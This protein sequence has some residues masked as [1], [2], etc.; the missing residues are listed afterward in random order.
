MVST[1][2]R[3]S[4]IFVSLSVLLLGHGLQQTLIPLSAVA[5]GWST[6][7]IALLGAG[8]F[9]GFIIGCYRIPRWIRRV[10]HARVF[11]ANAGL[12]VLAVLCFKF[13]NDL[14]AWI[15]LRALTGFS[16]AG[17]YLVIESWLNSATPNERRGTV[18]SF[19]TV[20]SLLALTVGQWFATLDLTTGIVLVAIA[21]S[22]AIYPIAL[23]GTSQPDVPSNVSLSF[24]ETYNASQVAPLNAAAAGFIMAL[25]WSVGAVF[26]AESLNSPHVGTTFVSFVLL[27]GVFSLLPIGRLSD[28]LDRRWVMFGTSAIGAATATYAWYT[29]ASFTLIMGSGFVI[30]ATAMPLYSLAIAHANDN[31]QDNFLIV[32]GTLLVANGIGAVVAP[33]LYAVLTA[34]LSI[35]DPFFL[36]ISLG[37]FLTSLWTFARIVIHPVERNYFEPYQPVSRTTFG[38]VELD[39][40]ADELTV[41]VNS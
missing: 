40:R 7:L 34:Y 11:A 32:G 38:A 23:S 2:T 8:Y 18:M 10:R 27:G 36:L 20:L 35:Q 26:A 13:T 5:L 21:F 9:C 33:L 12:A 17:L 6:S 22:V 4:S 31:A 1:L 14:W 39:P 24:S 41:E 19:Y 29:P 25:A 3:L 30:G 16:F 37:F 28:R 15:V